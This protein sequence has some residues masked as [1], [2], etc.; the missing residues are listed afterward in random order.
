MKVKKGKRKK[1]KRRMLVSR[2]PKRFDIP[3]EEGE[4]IE[5][6]KLPWVKLREAR[7]ENE[8][9]NRAIAREFGAEFVKALASSDDDEKAERRAKKL[10]KDQQYD[11]SNF[12]TH[13]LLKAGLVG[14]SYT[15]TSKEKPETE[16]MV[17]IKD[18]VERIDE[19]T[20]TWIKQ[21]I[22]DY[23]KP[24]SEKEEKNS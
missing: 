24:P 9:E 11:E 20:V 16:V 12:G 15:H 17:P 7:K 1:G 19:L 21:T 13:T 23:T 10:I 6:V 5:I 4:W 18:G 2:E 22:I 14:W 3:H 8:K